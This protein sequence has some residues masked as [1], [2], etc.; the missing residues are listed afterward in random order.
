MTSQLAMKISKEFISLFLSCMWYDSVMKNLNLLTAKLAEYAEHFHSQANQSKNHVSSPLGAWMLLASA[1]TAS[2]QI[3]ADSSKRDTAYQVLGMDLQQAESVLSAL[4]K[5]SELNYVS[6]G[7]SNP[8]NV[9]LFP[10]LEKWLA[11][12][13]KIP[14]TVGLPT[15]QE[16][17]SW[18][19]SH[20]KGLI[21]QFPADVS[22]ATI[23][24][25]ANL[26]YAKFE[27]TDK[28]DVVA[29]TSEE[30]S[31]WNVDKM[32]QSNSNQN[33]AQIVTHKGSEFLSYTVSSVDGST[34]TLFMPADT[35][36]T[37]KDLFEVMYGQGVYDSLGDLNGT[38]YGRSVMK[39]SSSPLVIARF[40]AWEADSLIGLN[41][42]FNGLFVKSAL[43]AFSHE[44]DKD[45][46]IVE[47]MQSAVAKF[48]SEGFEAAAL[49][50]MS[51]A[52]A[53]AMMPAPVLCH[54]ISFSGRIGF[55]AET[56]KIPTFSGIIVVGSEAT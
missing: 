26:I 56:G 53:S 32:L 27:W 6:A 35:S 45:E 55:V 11:D 41:D 10:A 50:S 15:Q 52:R 46:L 22:P 47:I 44:D 13:T 25:L 39:S 9:P 42:S 34:V 43:E 28:M 8:D 36:T 33:Y 48:N 24:I 14:V 18:A 3:K 29:A 16:L 51:F 38:N 2:E 1:L 37:D 40:P 30:V 21:K 12:N 7:W 19:D 5:K 49:T 20:S 54:E 4:L 31:M 23:L 17:D